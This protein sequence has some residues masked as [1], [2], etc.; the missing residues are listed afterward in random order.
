M[1]RHVG[2]IRIRALKPHL[3]V[4]PTGHHQLSKRENC[5]HR[6]QINVGGVGPELSPE[7]AEACPAVRAAPAAVSPLHQYPTR[8][9]LREVKKFTC[10]Y[11]LLGWESRSR[12]GLDSGPCRST[13]PSR[14]PGGS[15]FYCCSPPQSNAAGYIGPVACLAQ[16]LRRRP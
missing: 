3:C 13:V 11:S 15:E 2:D 14:A 1:A 9:G 10:V 12:I 8:S 6:H 7:V 5:W 4:A 16:N